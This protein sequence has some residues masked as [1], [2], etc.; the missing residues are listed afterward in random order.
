MPRSGS[1]A[2]GARIQSGQQ[3]EQPTYVGGQRSALVARMRNAQQLEQPTRVGG[4]RSTLGARTWR[5]RIMP[6]GGSSGPVARRRR[7]L[8][9]SVPEGARTRQSVCCGAHRGAHRR[10]WRQSGSRRWASRPVYN[11]DCA[12]GQ[13]HCAGGHDQAPSQMRA[14]A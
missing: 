3:P 10:R 13:R 12:D 1:I 9:E 4:Q 5:L 11:S 14:N 6:Q 8:M 2:L 7:C